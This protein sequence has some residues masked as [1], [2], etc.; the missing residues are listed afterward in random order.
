MIFKRIDQRIGKIRVFN[1]SWNAYIFLILLIL[2]IDFY[3]FKF[4]IFTDLQNYPLQLHLL[5]FI[6]FL[7]C[8]HSFI[9]QV[10]CATKQIRRAHSCNIICKFGELMHKVQGL[11]TWIR[12]YTVGKINHKKHIFNQP[13]KWFN[14]ILMNNILDIP[15]D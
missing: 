11:S 13:L 2:I 9:H 8:E 10:N 15:D 3:F 5:I 7:F 6:I 12:N 4:L 14:H 1:E